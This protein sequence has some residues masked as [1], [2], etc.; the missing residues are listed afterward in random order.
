MKN[1]FKWVGIVALAAVLTFGLLGC[2]EE[3]SGGSGTTPPKSGDA[4]L[5]KIQFGEAVDTAE[6]TLG[7]VIPADE[8]VE[9]QNYGSADPDFVGT[10]FVMATADLAKDI[11]LTLSPGATAS[12]LRG[13]NGTGTANAGALAPYEDDY[14]DG[15]PNGEAVSGLAAKNILY[16]QVKNGTKV[17]Y[18]A[19][20]VDTYQ[21]A[22]NLSKLASGGTEFS[23]AAALGT[24]VTT[25][26]AVATMTKGKIVL[27]V[28]SKDVALVATVSTA[29][30]VSY[31]KGAAAPT[32]DDVFTA[33]EPASTTTASIPGPFNNAEFLY[34]RVV[35]QNNANRNYYATEI[36]MGRLAVIT[37][38]T[39]GSVSATAPTPAQT[40]AGATKGVFA[41]ASGTGS[42]LAVSGL[43]DGA[44]AVFAK[45]AE[46]GA[47]PADTAF[48]ET[49]PNSFD[50]GDTI[51]IKVTALNGGAFNYYAYEVQIGRVATLATVTVNGAAA[52]LGTPTT[53]PPV[54]G[55]TP[56]AGQVEAGEQADVGSAIV[57]TATANSGATVTWAM[58]SGTVEPTVYGT[59]TPLKFTSTDDHLYIKV[60]SA[61]TKVTNVYKIKVVFQAVLHVYYGKPQIH[62]AGDP[63]YIDPLFTATDLQVYDIS[64]ANLA[65]MT[66][67]EAFYLTVD[68]TKPGHT[69]AK[70]VA[71]WDDDGLYIYANVDFYD[72]YENAAAKT[73]GTVTPRVLKYIQTS[74]QEHNG[75]NFEI[76]TNE[77]YQGNKTGDYGMQYR[78]Q[79]QLPATTDQ[80]PYLS[81]A[82]GN[83]TGITPAP[84][85]Q[86][87]NS[88]NYK[89]WVRTADGTPTGKQIGYS[90]IAKVPWV[91]KG[92]TSTSDVFDTATG[93][94]KASTTNLAEGPR[95]GMELQINTSSR[96]TNARDAILTWNGIGTSAYQNCASYGVVH[97][98]FGPGRERQPNIITQPQDITVPTGWTIPARTVT[99]EAG[100][101]IEWFSATSESD[102]TG[103][104]AGA[105]TTSGTTNVTSSLAITDNTTVGKTYY[106]AVV[107]KGTATT[108]SDKICVEIL[109]SDNFLVDLGDRF[110]GSAATPDAAITNKTNQHATGF[111]APPAVV[112][113]NAD[114]VNDTSD[115]IKATF[116]LNQ[117]NQ[118]LSFSLTTAQITLLRLPDVA[119]IKVE[120]EY[121]LAAE[122]LG[123]YSVFVAN[124]RVNNT[125][126]TYNGFALSTAKK[127]P[128]ATTATMFTETIAKNT[129]AGAATDLSNS[130]FVIRKTTN[131][132]ETNDLTIK[133]IK[134]TVLP[135]AQ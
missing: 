52:T 10:V 16:I 67:L 72:F 29:A 31:F 82:F 39:I 50:D 20:T 79:S 108:K 4:F 95:I 22:A 28:A 88:G 128:L 44:K 78:I 83:A 68:E 114:G 81:G 113:V 117:T 42:T 65:E 25:F 132:I 24:A 23:N 66:P 57:A 59:T 40:A 63:T 97:L 8:Y 129:N 126:N 100:T 71:L 131:A 36:D 55:A 75:D 54:A 43:S 91:L 33:V 104:T 134:I 45:V 87:R 60:V 85:D 106:W 135:A 112:N 124:P 90:I 86:F 123:D 118:S 69:V 38:A 103:V 11:T 70:A 125:A 35:S 61:N 121:E 96:S 101:T 115:G 93:Y 17:N 3:D 110:T 27:P 119:R 13:T 49:A 26:S 76:F 5:T 107:T 94:V 32:S 92:Q 7:D 14:E 47:A 116:A 89:A 109:A 127:I 18:Y 34:I 56:T 48:S 19:F 2:P 9:G 15:I 120:V 30:K 21:N 105:G 58:G 99:A 98:V 77:R 46:N 6:F 73:A 53:T 37:G 12:M 62:K 111:R 102:D 80:T 74:G 1:K 84:L 133:S 51:Y 64:R 130:A 122:S 41:L